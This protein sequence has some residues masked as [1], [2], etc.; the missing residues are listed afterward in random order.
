VSHQCRAVH[1]GAGAAPQPGQ[2]HIRTQVAFQK[3]HLCEKKQPVLEISKGPE[4]WLRSANAPPKQASIQG[5]IVS[6]TYRHLTGTSG[7]LTSLGR[8]INCCLFSR[9]AHR[10]RNYE[11]PGGA[12]TH[13]NST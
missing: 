12:H 11:H 5:N 9:Q 1:L 6:V 10:K 13:F 2:Q 8:V 3:R 7:I 4:G